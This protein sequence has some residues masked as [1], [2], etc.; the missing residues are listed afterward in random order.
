[1]PRENEYALRLPIERRDP[2][3]DLRPRDAD[4]RLDRRDREP[5]RQMQGR[6]D[7]TL[8]RASPK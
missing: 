4:V 5:Q 1:M 2:R 7:D 6:P 8:T 3:Y